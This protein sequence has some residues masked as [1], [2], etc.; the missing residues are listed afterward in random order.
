MKARWEYETILL[1]YTIRKEGN[2]MKRLIAIFM[3]L[4]LVLGMSSVSVWADEANVWKYEPSMPIAPL[5]FGTCVV[6]DKIYVLGGY[7]SQSV[8]IYDTKNQSWEMGKPMPQSALITTKSAS[9]GNRIYTIS[10]MNGSKS[11]M[12]IYDTST[13]EWT[14]KTDIP[15]FNDEQM[16]SVGNK[17]YVINRK[18]KENRIF[19]YDT[20]SEEWLSS[21]SVTKARSEMALCTKGTKI[22]VLGGQEYDG[23]W[24]GS[25]LMEVYDINT[26]TWETIGTMAAARSSLSAIILGN[27]LY[28]MGGNNSSN[29]FNTV[30]IYDTKTDTWSKGESLNTVR[31]NFRAE[32][33]DGKIYAIGGTDKY[34]SGIKTVES[35]QIGN[36]P[37][38]SVAKLSVLLN[39]G[40]NVQLSTSFDLN[41]NK[42]FT[43]TSTNESVAT[44]DNNGK[45]I[46]VGAGDADIY[47]E[48]ADGTFKEYIP[49]R[50]VEGMADE[51]RLAV[52]LKA[53][54]KAK[55]HLTD[56]PSKVTWSSMDESTVTVSADGQVTGVK[57]GLAIVQAELDGQTYQIYI[58]V[59]G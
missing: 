45:V 18:D 21:E 30:E 42:N 22:Y 8:T 46:A 13:D 16:V 32:I 17:I 51:L 12:Q 5:N 44:V 39:T 11:L 40:E 33:A 28:A 50:V 25:N 47:A 1:K 49:V 58:R 14:V 20:L 9:I 2:N 29:Y 55:L 57:K 26:D 48:S 19:I 35:L 54:E 59:N 7:G 36:L 15:Y 34:G 37:D 38:D 27:K 23:N 41:N 52:H 4:C 31:R 56:D 43:W 53:G 24:K 3:T 10:R 6:G